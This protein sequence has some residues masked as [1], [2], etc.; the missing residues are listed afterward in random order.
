[1]IV[2]EQADLKDAKE[3]L[4]LYK[5]LLEEDLP[6]LIESPIPTLS[7][8]M[9]YI[10]M[11][12]ENRGLL[13]LARSS[14]KLI[15]SCSLIRGSAPYNEHI[16]S[17]GLFI[18]KSHRGIGIG[19]SLIEKSIKWCNKNSIQKIELEALCNNPAVNLY[20]RLGFEV[21][22]CKRRAIKKGKRYIDLLI[23]AKCLP[24]N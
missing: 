22:G 16:C 18:S 4:V 3:L 7:K 12:G 17:L 13:L 20:K 5:D 11:H 23:M 15:G 8:E 10:R 19:T 24:E 6:Y 14:G 9:D 2:L 1:M 21:E